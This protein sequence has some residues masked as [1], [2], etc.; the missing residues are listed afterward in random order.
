[1]RSKFLSLLAALAF[2]LPLF[3][4]Q[5][6]K[7]DENTVTWEISQQQ[8]DGDHFRV[9][10]TAHILP[11]YHIYDT[12]DKYSGTELE[13]MGN[14]FTSDGILHDVSRPASGLYFDTASFYFDYTATG[15]G[16]GIM[17][18]VTWTPCRE[19]VCGFPDFYEFRV[20]VP[21]TVLNA[22]SYNDI[23]PDEEGAAIPAFTL[24]EQDSTAGG[25]GSLWGLL[26]EAILCG[27]LMLLTPCVFPMVPMT[28]SYF[29]KGSASPAAGRFKALMY[30]VFIVVLYTLPIAVLIFI[31]WLAGGDDTT[32]DIFNWFSTHWIPNI[33][34]FIVFIVF[35]I[36][37]FGAFEI[38]APSSLVNKSDKKSD[39]GGLGGIFFMALSL[40]LVSFSC[41]VPI[42][43]T[44][45][46]QSVRGAFWTPILTMFV[47]SLAFALPFTLLALFPSFLKKMKSGAWLNSVKVV[48]GF[49]ELALAFKFLSMADQ[50]YHW[51]ILDREV[52]LAIWIVIFS[53]MGLYLL[54]KI[55]FAHDDQPV[56]KLS[57]VRLG[58]VITVFSFVV[59]MIP[60]M[61]GAPLKALS[62]YLPPLESQ[63]FNL[64]NPGG[65][66]AATIQ[67]SDSDMARKYGL[68][69]PLGLQGYFSLEEGFEAARREGK[70]V[71]VD[72]SGH[73]CANCREM[74][75]RVW[76]DG[77]V[78]RML[79][80]EFV[81]VALFTD[82][83]TA[84][85]EEDWV[86]TDSG[87]VLK[88]LGAANA[89]IAL[90]R[91]GVNGKPNYVILDENGTL[92][93]P[94]RGYDLS[95]SGFLDFLRQGLDAYANR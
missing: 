56:E 66:S 77:D 89:Y 36:S 51:G 88:E 22:P 34:F 25:D 19:E 17:G 83:K 87:K 11:G 80:D 60:G 41:T 73:S 64:Y 12:K 24:P 21:Q 33:L 54:G 92:L 52:Y 79:R 26:V 67:M 23:D 95:V 50:S 62:G 44:V 4:Q 69:M 37:F 27:L 84:L 16:G 42:V 20:E 9:T 48:F 45:L 47:F 72:I 31:T 8:L 68:K 75:N 30:G 10:L 29:L 35:A 90:Q 65:Y 18:V 49:I 38:T 32:A 82:D 46:I 53:L 78:F 55:R 81:L 58:L 7:V 70:P 6:G 76:S 59:Y 43:G 63:D 15:E 74:E 71:F 85:L 1:M 61:W 39:K 5:A 14:G 40:V 57:I 13:I 86:T 28:V 3:G 94:V 2:V 91:F 93:S